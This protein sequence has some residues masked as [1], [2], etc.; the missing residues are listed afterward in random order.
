MQQTQA[1]RQI[2]LQ[3]RRTFLAPRE[4]VFRAWT[5]A[6]ELAAWF[7][8]SPDFTIVIPEME[9]RVGGRCRVEMHHKAGDVHRLNSTYCEVDPPNRLAFTWRWEPEAGSAETLVTVEFHALGDATEIILTHER[10]ASDEQKQKHDH[11]WTGC[12][13]QLDKFLV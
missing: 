6:K 9:L 1:P 7:A 11:G 4:R 5:E 10:F 13:D 8:P 12:F 2:A 3:V